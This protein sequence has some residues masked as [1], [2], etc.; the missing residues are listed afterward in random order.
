MKPKVKA[1]LELGTDINYKQDLVPTLEQ[2]KEN[3]IIESFEVLD[4]D[5]FE[6]FIIWS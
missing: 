5:E 6:Q 3:G 2:L 4:E 1:V